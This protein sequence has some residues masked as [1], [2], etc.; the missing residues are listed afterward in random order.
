M[1]VTLLCYGNIYTCQLCSF[2]NLYVWDSAPDTTPLGSK[3]VSPVFTEV[4]Y[5]FI[6]SFY[7]LLS[8]YILLSVSESVILHSIVEY[9]SPQG[10]HNDSL[11]IHIWF[12]LE[13]LQSLMLGLFTPDYNHPTPILQ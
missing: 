4:A 7:S 6:L 13:L 3:P 11:G 10:E 12:D 9:F 1:N 8:G 2:S 5:P